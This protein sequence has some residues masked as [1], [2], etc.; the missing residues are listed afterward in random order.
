M[1]NFFYHFKIIWRNLRNSKFYTAINI[2]G[3]SVALAVC[4]LIS[5]WVKDEM[6]YDRHYKNGGHIYRVLTFNK[7][8]SEYWLTS[9]AP[10]ASFMQTDISQIEKYCRIGSY[11][12]N[13]CN[14]LDDGNTKIRDFSILA[15]DT[16]FFGM[17]DVV[18]TSGDMHEPL[19]DDLSLIISESKAKLFFG[20]DD[21]IGK[22]LKTPF[23][24]SFHVTGVMKDIPENTSNCP[25]IL[26]RF[27]VQQRTFEGNGKWKL[28]EEDWGSY[29][30][31]TYFMLA[32]GSDTETIANKM[33]E[34]SND[35]N[36][37]YRLQPLHE[38]HLYNLAGQPEGIKN[39]YIF[40]I[41][42]ILILVIACINHVNLVTARASK[43]TREIGV[44]KI[45]GAGKANILG[46]FMGETALM[47]VFSML[48]ATVLIYL[49]LPF[50]NDL[51]GKNMQFNLFDGSI[52]QAYS[53]I[54]IVALLLAGLYP[55]FTLASF[56]P[57]DAFNNGTRGSGKGLLRKVLVVVQFAFSAALIVATIVTASQL[58]YMQNMNPGYDK[59]NVFTVG[60]QG[61][62]MGQNRIMVERLSSEPA[63][64]GVSA[65]SFYEMIAPGSRSD[66]WKDKNNQS[67]NFAWAMVDH[68]FFPLMN[69]PIVEGTNFRDGEDMHKRGTIMNETAARLIGGGESVIGMNLSYG[70]GDTEVVGVVK[71]FNYDNLHVEIKPLIINCVTE[72]EPNLYVKT[73]AGKTSQAIA[74][75]ETVW[76]EYNADYDFSYRFL[77][78]SFDTMYKSDLRT[79]MLF[80]I[81]AFI[82][83]LISCLGLF[84]LVTYTAETKTKEIGIRKVLGASVVNMLSKEFLLLVGIAMLIAFPV[85]YYLLNKMLQDYAYRIDIS[86]WM[87]A[88]AALITIVL[89]LFTVGFQAIK[90]AMANPVEAI[91][92]N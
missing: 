78:D 88:V 8:S 36:R 13:R 45:I 72:Y 9:P 80:N 40:S 73:A 68:G 33:A 71:D 6:G 64:A 49:L 15:V 31:E 23:D 3:L 84:G 25:D 66:I 41:I 46:Q 87:F 91:K 89:T 32:T 55:A 54:G 61:E 7:G 29:M 37:N 42:A 79:G 19:P 10:M 48:I 22:Q 85:A 4:I 2:G 52:I 63:I 83:I 76:K 58:R 27:D 57:L 17:F 47:L 86:W 90:A 12:G 82:A 62:S 74:A 16:S 44:R 43:R 1:K 21:P 24:F 70:G 39:V 69:I 77:D 60:L 75:V 65:S 92:S 38:M 28:I 26:V 59:E 11:Y 18:L 35:S 20:N 30:Y 5:L 50:Y 34:K 14:Y 56:R 67:P 51:A 81:F 53:V